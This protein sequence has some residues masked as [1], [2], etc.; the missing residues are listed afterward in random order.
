MKILTFTNRFADYMSD[1]D[2]ESH[3]KKWSCLK[4]SIRDYL[5]QSEMY[6]TWEHYK[7][8]NS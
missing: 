6:F 5:I 8:E 4:L 2:D 1:N 7:G 3:I